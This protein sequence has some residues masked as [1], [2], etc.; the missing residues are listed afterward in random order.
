MVADF[1]Y[2]L[3]VS[4]DTQ[5]P[6][7]PFFKGG[8]EGGFY[9]RVYQKSPLLPFTKRGDN[10]PLNPP[11]PDKNI[12]GQVL[13]GNK[14]LIYK[15]RDPFE[16]ISFVEWSI[17]DTALEKMEG[18]YQVHG[19]AVVKDNRGIILPAAPGS[20]KTMLTVGLSM[21]GFQCLS[22]DIV[23]IETQSL[24]I[25][26]FPRNIFITEE[27][28]D[29][30]EKYGYHLPLRKSEWKDMGGWDFIFNFKPEFSPV[31]FII[32]PQYN[33]AAKTELKGFSKGAAIFE[34]IRE[35][36]NFHKFRDRGIDLIQSLVER[37]ECF[38]L[39]VNNLNEA[40]DTISRLLKEQK[41][42]ETTRFHQMD[43]RI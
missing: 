30:F 11:F 16:F 19:G 17:I 27:K 26:P 8:I 31:D 15:T 1:K 36:F 29:I 37:A 3:D 21:N 18:F 42:N 12:Q 33:P 5:S 24:K 39:T 25:N 13:R 22:D 43:T 2:F 28:K 4:E 34:I 9:G 10:N 6:P 38:Q 23:L 7:P 32:F 35:S 40:I 14:K 41:L 20:G